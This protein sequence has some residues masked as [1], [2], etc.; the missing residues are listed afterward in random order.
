MK[1]AF[2][3]VTF[4]SIPSL[5]FPATIYVP[6][7]YSTIQEGIDAAVNGDSIVVKPG[8]Y[9]ENI[10]FKGKSIVVKSQYGP[11]RTIIDGNMTTSV[12]TFDNTEGTDSILQGFTVTNG[13]GTYIPGWGFCGGGIYCS[14]ASPTLTGNIITQNDVDYFGG[15]IY[16]HNCSPVITNNIIDSNSSLSGGGIGCWT[17]FATIHNNTICRNQSTNGGGLWCS[18]FSQPEIK[19]SIFW[20]NTAPQG[21]EMWIGNISIVFISYSDLKGGKTN[22]YV[23][24]GCSLNWGDGMITSN[25]MF[26]DLAHG[27]FHL[28]YSS[29]CRNAGDNSGNVDMGADEFYT[30]LYCTGDFTPG[31]DIEGKLIGLPGTSPVGLFLGSGV[32]EPPVS[33]MWG[34]FYLEPPYFPFLLVPIPGDGILVLLATIPVTPPAPYDLPMQALIGDNP[35]SLTNLCVLEVR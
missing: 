13:K 16:C 31:G 12:V 33:T 6:D 24:S 23:A 27:D 1:T 29:P 30:H 7:D 10:D 28:L 3:L 34:N 35:D 21:Q 32:L 14:Q 19:N 8:K 5:A 9:V 17:S 25:P 11:E 26:V 18:Y 2:I 20:E 4:L 15:G 22:V